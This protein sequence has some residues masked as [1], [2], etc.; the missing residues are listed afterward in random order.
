[1]SSH[2]KP[3][4]ISSRHFQPG[5]RALVRIDA[6]LELDKN[7][8]LVDDWR[9]KAALPTLKLLSQADQQLTLITHLGRPNGRRMADLRLLPIARRLTALL[10]G[11][12]RPRIVRHQPE[13]VESPIFE[14]QYQLCQNIRLLEN[15]RFDASEE[16]NERGLARLLTEQVDYFVNESF[17]TAHRQS[18]STSGVAGLVPSYLGLRFAEELAHLNLLKEGSSQRRPHLLIIGGAKLPEKLGLL[19]ELAKLADRILLGGV[20]ANVFLEAKGEDIGRSVSDPDYLPLAKKLLADPEFAAKLSLPTDYQI[21][22]DRI[23]DLGPRTIQQY[24]EAINEAGLVFWAGSLGI[25]EQPSSAVGSQALARALA[26]AKAIKLIG[27]GDTATDLARFKLLDKM[28]YV[29]TG[30][31]A[32]LTYL[33]NQPLPAYQA[34]STQPAT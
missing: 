15:L 19:P 27:G 23:V 13:A 34:L 29:S 12:S 26:D 8:Q 31:G 17:G 6:D 14:T 1:M 28:D 18:V 33:A 11:Y 30:G 4:L 24:I 9:L 21:E 3:A 20:V 5:Q 10:T 32:A 7:G 25:C 16:A 22:D 2:S